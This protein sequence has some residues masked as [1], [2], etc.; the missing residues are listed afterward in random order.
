MAGLS[1]TSSATSVRVSRPE[2]I[3]D[4]ADLISAAGGQAVA[5][6]VDHTIPAEVA[7]LMVRRGGEPTGESNAADRPAQPV[8]TG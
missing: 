3:D 8:A 5:M 2:T 6:R 4:T 7:P 1:P